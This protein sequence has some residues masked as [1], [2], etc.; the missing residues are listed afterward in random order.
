MWPVF[1]FANNF[2]NV[3]KGLVNTHYSLGLYQ[4]EAITF[5]GASGVVSLPSLWASYFPNEV[6]AVSKT[7]QMEAGKAENL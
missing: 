7:I 1:G 4:Q 2:G 5:D 3:G 6:A